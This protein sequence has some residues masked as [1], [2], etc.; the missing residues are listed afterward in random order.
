MVA[1]KDNHRELESLSLKQRAF[2]LAYTQSG[3]ATASAKAAGYKGT[4]KAL[5]VNGARL[6]GNVRVQAALKAMMQ[7]ALEKHSITLDRI[8]EEYEKVAF[9]APEK[10]KGK[11]FEK[12]RALRDLAEWRGMFDEKQ[13]IDPQQPRLEHREN[14][15]AEEARVELLKFLRQR[16][17]APR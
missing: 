2:V 1:V 17:K 7:P 16:R 14:I 13:R 11:V 3:N 8:I 12:L 6:L 5:G 15:T 4:D 9:A 10:L